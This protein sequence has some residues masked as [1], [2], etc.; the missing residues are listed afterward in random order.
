MRKR[1]MG[2]HGSLEEWANSTSRGWGNRGWQPCGQ[3]K[4]IKIE[5]KARRPQNG[6]KKK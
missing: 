5:K 1:G 2:R 3:H 6:V 4:E